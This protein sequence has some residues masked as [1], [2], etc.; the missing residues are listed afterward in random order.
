MD[1]L[2]AS[3]GRIGNQAFFFDFFDAVS[4]AVSSSV[5]WRAVDVDVIEG[6]MT[7]LH[8]EF[9]MCTDVCDD[10]DWKETAAGISSRME[11]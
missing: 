8:F 2:R 9:V 3:A 4:V 10:D 1:G 6:R 7:E 11:R 5:D